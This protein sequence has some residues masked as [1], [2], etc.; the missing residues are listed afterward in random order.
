MER[1]GVK[2]MVGK[3]KG[4]STS[5]IESDLK[6]GISVRVRMR[7]SWMGSCRDSHLEEA[8]EEVM[9]VKGKWQSDEGEIVQDG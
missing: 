4:T 1:R 2:A 9:L 5:T 3:T 6:G 7:V 8:G